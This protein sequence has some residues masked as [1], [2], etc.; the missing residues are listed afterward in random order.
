MKKKNHLQ[1]DYDL[2]QK[3]GLKFIE[4][5]VYSY[6]DSWQKSNPKV[7]VSNARIAKDL[8][9][10]VGMIKSYIKRLVDKGLLKRWTH[11]GTRYMKVINIDS[12]NTDHGKQTDH[13]IESKLTTSRKQTD[14]T[15]DNK[16]SR[17]NN[18]YNNNNKN[19]YKPDLDIFWQKYILRVG[20]KYITKP[21]YIELLNELTKEEYKQVENYLEE[22]RKDPYK[23][24]I[25]E[26]LQNKLYIKQKQ[27]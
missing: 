10:G 9:L 20:Y 26:L 18:S 6:L 16:L 14:H 27:I 1:I 11:N 15:I 21:G 22:N 8:N 7:F 3:S 2:L 25:N 23:A 24:T 5:G 12:Q 19:N 4:A 17:Y 13:T